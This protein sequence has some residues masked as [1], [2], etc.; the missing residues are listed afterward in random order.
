MSQTVTLFG[1]TRYIPEGKERNWD[2]EMTSLL[3]DLSL[4][5][6]DA[7]ALDGGVGLVKASV[8]DSAVTAAMTLTQTHSVHRVA[9]SGGAQSL[10]GTTAIANG[11]YDEQKLTLVGTHDT[12]TVTVPDGANTELNGP[13]TLADDE[14]LK[15]RWDDTDSQWVEEYRST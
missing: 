13:M 5:V 6:N 15:L 11:S 2:A 9:G 8:T 10:D 7:I 1:T 12:N 4:A 3:Y 14:V